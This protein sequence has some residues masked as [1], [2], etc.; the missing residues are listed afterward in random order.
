MT[1][2]TGSIILN[3]NRPKWRKKAENPPKISAGGE[4]AAIAVRAI[5]YGLQ[6]CRMGGFPAG[7]HSLSR[8]SSI[9]N[10]PRMRQAF[11]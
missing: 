4:T 8:I 7:R 1:G 5:A 6:A 11:T 10:K 9:S 2:T 3:A